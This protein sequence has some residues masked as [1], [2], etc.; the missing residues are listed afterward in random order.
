MYDVVS[1]IK[2]QPRVFWYFSLL[3]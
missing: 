1:D 2:R 3:S